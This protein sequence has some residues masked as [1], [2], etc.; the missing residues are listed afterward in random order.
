M[1]YFTVSF[2]EGMLLIG[3]TAGSTVKRSPMYGSAYCGS[4][5][6]FRWV[7][8]ELERNNRSSAGVALIII[9]TQAIDEIKFGRNS[10]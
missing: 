6:L 1:T 4:L 3:S 7:L 9:I 10:V 8:R 5:N 2:L